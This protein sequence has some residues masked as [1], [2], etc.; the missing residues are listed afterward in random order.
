MSRWT[1]HVAPW[2]LPWIPQSQATVDALLA[3]FSTPL[4]ILKDDRRSLVILLPELPDSNGGHAL[5]GGGPWVCKR[6][7]WRDG[8]GWHRLLSLFQPGEMHRAFDAALRLLELGIATPQPLLLMEHRRWGLMVES[9]LVYRYVPGEAVGEEQWPLVVE[10]L[11]SLHSAGLRHGDPH[12]A[13]W[14][15]DGLGGV[16][17][18]DSGPRPMRFLL[19]DDAYDFVLLRNCVPAVRPLLP[20]QDTW[21]WRVAEARNAWVQGWRRVKRKVRRR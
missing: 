1:L 15:K 4:R 17:A 3:A 6:P 20:L 16:V 9:W 5:S 13:N 18:L 8:R 21:K 19:A 11:K 12:L 14:L 10:A 7:R 2:A